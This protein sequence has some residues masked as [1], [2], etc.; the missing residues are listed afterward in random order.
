MIHVHVYKVMPYKVEYD[1][2]TDDPIKAKQEALN[3][4]K[5]FYDTNGVLKLIES[6]CTFIALIPN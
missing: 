1:I 4:A 6:D 3:D 2:D 5:Q